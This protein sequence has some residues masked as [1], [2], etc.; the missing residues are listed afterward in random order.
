MKATNLNYL[1]IDQITNFAH[2]VTK[3]PQT[4]EQ[5]TGNVIKTYCLEEP[6]NRLF[7]QS[8]G[9]SDFE[10]IRLNDTRDSILF[11]Q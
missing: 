4:K 7:V 9:L 6:K 10:T 3:E 5:F 11:N 2:L 8:I 1:F